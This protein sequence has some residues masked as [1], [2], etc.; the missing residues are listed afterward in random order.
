MENKEIKKCINDLKE[1]LDIIE[2]KLED[3]RFFNYNLTYDDF[4]EI[5]KKINKIVEEG[6]LG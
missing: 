4:L 2:K 5:Y 1:I 3:H 6:E